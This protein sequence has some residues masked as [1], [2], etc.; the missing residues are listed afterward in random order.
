MSL[1]TSR[2]DAISIVESASNENGEYTKFSNGTMICNMKIL[3]SADGNWIQD[4][5]MYRR[6]I[7]NVTFP[8]P[9]KE[10]PTITGI[11][12]ATT[13]NRVCWLSTRNIT[14]SKIETVI[15][16]TYWNASAV[17]GTLNFIA[18]GKWK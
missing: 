2:N 4:N 13:T 6:T 9:F 12:N 7:E 14:A 3:F 10:I 17:I 11:F 18:I 16:S 8:M 5:I 1:V 15:I